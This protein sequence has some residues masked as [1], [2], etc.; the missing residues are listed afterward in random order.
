MLLDCPYRFLFWD[1]PAEMNS[2]C[3]KA[4]EN[5]DILCRDV[6]SIRK[7]FRKV[8]SQQQCARE[9]CVVHRLY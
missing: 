2:I 8:P 9:T 1:D 4:P 5:K 3:N 7:I 6:N